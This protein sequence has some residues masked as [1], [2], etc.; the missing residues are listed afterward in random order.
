M[1]KPRRHMA[2]KR[3][4]LGPATLHI[5]KIT[6][7]PSEVVQWFRRKVRRETEEGLDER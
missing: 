1:M 4:D 6:P 7:S 2:R 5:E 3:E